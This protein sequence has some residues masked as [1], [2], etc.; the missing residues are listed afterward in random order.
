MIEEEWGMRIVRIRRS[1]WR[2]VAECDVLRELNEDVL[3]QARQQKQ[4]LV[5]SF[6]RDV[7]GELRERVYG[8]V[9]D[10]LSAIR[11]GQR[12]NS[13]SATQLRNLVET[14][15]SLNFWNDEQIEAQVASIRKLLDTPASERSVEDI[16]SVLQEIGAEARLALIELDRTPRRSGREVGVPDEAPEIEQ[17]LRQRRATADAGAVEAM[18]LVRQGRRLSA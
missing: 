16:Q 12:W 8:V 2:I 6:M 17:T 15:Q 7:Q 1:G 18:D 10:A 9:L 11:K 3:A 14:V 5:T 13:R 4:E